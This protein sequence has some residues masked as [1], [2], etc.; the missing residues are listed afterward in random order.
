MAKY[1][2]ET[3]NGTYIVETEDPARYGSGAVHGWAYKAAN[4]LLNAP[5]PS[6][7]YR[8]KGD[9]LLDG[10]RNAL[11]DF[12]EAP[13]NM[14]RGA[15]KG[16]LNTAA[17]LGSI[18]NKY[19][20][21]HTDL[22]QDNLKDLTETHG[23]AQGL[24]NAAEQVGEFMAGEGVAKA[25][26]KVPLLAN[27]ATKSKFAQKGIDLAGRVAANAGVSAA[28]SGGDAGSTEVGAALPV[29]GDAVGAGLGFVGRKAS[30][31]YKKAT[32][33]ERLSPGAEA[34]AN[35]AHIP[36]RSS[37]Y[38]GNTFARHAENDLGHSIVADIYHPQQVARQEGLRTISDDLSGSASGDEAM[39]RLK[40]RLDE[41][42]YDH[43]QLGNEAYGEHR[44]LLKKADT[45]NQN[46]QPGTIG[47]TSGFR[48]G[49]TEVAAS[50]QPSQ[51]SWNVPQYHGVSSPV[52]IKEAKTSLQPIVEAVQKRQAQFPSM[53]VPSTFGHVL[54]IVNSPDLVSA[55]AADKLLSRLKGVVRDREFAGIMNE[56]QGLAAKAIGQMEPELQKSLEAMSPEARDA[57]LRG[58]AEW[59][60]RN[61][62][63]DLSKDLFGNDG[64]I[65]KGSLDKL[66]APGDYNHEQLL[67]P[68][69][70]EAPEMKD[71]VGSAYL[72][73]LFEQARSSP[74]G[75]HKELGVIRQW[76]K[77]GDKT[78]AD[79][80]GPEKTKAID[81]FLELAGRVNW[82]AN[83]SG[84]GVMRAVHH[85][86]RSPI[87]YLVGA[88]TTAYA[89]PA[90]LPVYMASL[91]ASRKFG[92]ILLQPGAP[93]ALRDMIKFGINSAKGRA[94]R[95]LVST[96][97][98]KM[99]ATE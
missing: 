74:T 14:A 49:S 26:T 61:A 47:N 57:L 70:Q 22:N 28:Q 78:K 32:V 95:A 48:W 77:L 72:N 54:D 34:M 40:K 52:D 1:K 13:T 35:N 51:V 30:S 93:N 5:L 55:D 16:I 27:I 53:G 75:F 36:L 7:Q 86:L 66:M 98:T 71:E 58:R 65:S 79:V 82:N 8:P 39:A 4:T 96:A 33:G 92:Q 59:K 24:G 19:L 62:V 42:V 23:F 99:G 10:A 45:A 11:T 60:Q 84:T 29:I 25:A 89:A 81:S 38:S 44:D 83:P 17:G 6:E 15:A 46:I 37:D 76:T 20:G 2:I 63:A 91:Y 12:G 97:L 69:L 73:H 50:G 88:G 21:A 56:S 41:R 31:F 64:Q 80:F 43:T 9:G 68:I 87:T 3:D 67:K 94:A 85:A 18:A 90:M